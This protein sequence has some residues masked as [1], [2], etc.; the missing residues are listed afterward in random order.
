MYES[1]RGEYKGREARATATQHAARGYCFVQRPASDVVHFRHLNYTCVMPPTPDQVTAGQAVYIRRTLRIYDLLVL[2]ISNRWVWKCR[3]P[4]LLQLYNENVSDNHLDVGVGTGYF[5]DHCRFPS[6]SPRVALLDLN[7][8]CLQAAADR[9]ARYRP[10]HY[11]ANILEPFA[12]DVPKFD[13]IGVNYV[14]HCLP[15]TIHEKSIALRHLSELLTPSG[16]IFGST[17]LHDGV[18]RSWPARRLMAYYNR[19]QIFC[20][21]D[22]NLQGLSAALA[23]EFPAFNIRTVGCA[24]LFTAR[25]TKS[26]G[27]DSPTRRATP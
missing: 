17:L 7:P 12:L 22:D 4:E 19:K 23:R 3:T 24:A 13:S 6:D 8:N 5:L 11:T 10:E 1:A 21:T 14:L 15:G 20:N 25:L 26:D 18:R 27:E 9:V 16:V 2:G